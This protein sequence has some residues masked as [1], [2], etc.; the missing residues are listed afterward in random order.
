VLEVESAFR[1]PTFRNYNW[2]NPQVGSTPGLGSASIVIFKLNNQPLFP[3]LNDEFSI[4]VHKTSNKEKRKELHGDGHLGAHENS[5]IVTII[6][7]TRPIVAQFFMKI[8][9]K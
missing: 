1:D 5:M 9:L 3:K 7:A 2:L 6:I 8:L 4:F